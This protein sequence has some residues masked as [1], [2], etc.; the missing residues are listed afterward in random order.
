MR[1]EEK[2]N[3]T[4]PIQNEYYT[5]IIP[6]KKLFNSTMIHEVVNRGDI[7]ALNVNTGIFTVISGKEQV[8]FIDVIILADTK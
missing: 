2:R 4:I 3:E 8:N 1:R 6:A 5:R 7:F